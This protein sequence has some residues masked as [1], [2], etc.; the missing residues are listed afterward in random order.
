[1]KT[2]ESETKKWKGINNRVNRIIWSAFVLLVLYFHLLIGTLLAIATAFYWLLE[3]HLPRI[4]LPSQLTTQ[5]SGDSDDWSTLEVTTARLAENHGWERWEV[6]PAQRRLNWNYCRGG[7][8]DRREVWEYELRGTALVVRLIES[9]K[10]WFDGPRYSVFEGCVVRTQPEDEYAK[11]ASRWK[12]A[13]EDLKKMMLRDTPDLEQAKLEKQ[14]IWHDVMQEGAPVKMQGALRYFVL[15]KCSENRAFL[16]GE[17]YR[18]QKAF[19]AVEEE[20]QQLGAVWD[21]DR[22]HYKAPA[23]AAEEVTKAISERLGTNQGL[24][25]F[26]VWFQELR[27]REDVMAVFKDK[28]IWN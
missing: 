6:Y 16:R 3:K 12:D 25:R 15:A 19:A 18:L 5:N 24:L 26:G 14:L 13:D 4:A 22:R 7:P 11:E 27:E 8:P 21:E 20:A 9:S 1:M 23:G 10:E 2:I 28:R 17:E